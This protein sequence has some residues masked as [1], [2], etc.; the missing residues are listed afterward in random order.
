MF[1]LEQFLIEEYASNP[2]G[3]KDAHAEGNP[4]HWRK[5][6]DWF[7]AMMTDI[8]DTFEREDEDYVVFQEEG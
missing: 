3:N 6:P 8:L 4:A 7:A 2:V 5:L 1:I